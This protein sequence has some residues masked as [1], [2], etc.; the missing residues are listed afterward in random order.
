MSDAG[1]MAAREA[2]RAVGV[3]LARL[4]VKGSYGD[5]GTFKSLILDDHGACVGVH[6]V[7]GMSWPAD[8]VILA[9]GAW[10]PSLLDLENQ[11]ES[12]VCGKR[13]D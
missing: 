3:E 1:W 9:T 4:G 12:K 10:S 6:T 13:K 5:A 8:L 2:L 11:C 7:D